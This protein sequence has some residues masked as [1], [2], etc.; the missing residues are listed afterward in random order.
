MVYNLERI[1]GNNYATKLL[2]LTLKRILS[3]PKL[4]NFLE[5]RGY[6]LRLCLHSFFNASMVSTLL[7]NSSSSKISW[8]HANQTD[9]M[10]ELAASSLLITDY[11]SVGFDFAF[12][13]KPVVLFM[14][15]LDEYGK[16]R[17]FY[18]NIDEL[19][20]SA[21][22]SP[23]ELINYLLE[24]KY[25]TNS[26]FRNRLPE[27]IDYEYVRSGKHIERM[28][29][30]FRNLQEHRITFIGYNFYGIGGTVLATRALAE[31][32][33]EQGYMV[34]LLSLK[35]NQ[36]PG[37]VP[38]A[39]NMKALYDEKAKTKRNRLK[40]FLF[41]SSKLYQWLRFD[42]DRCHLIPY[43]G[44][45]LKRWLDQAGS[46]TVISTRESLHPFLF[47]GSSKRIKNKVYYYHCVASVFETVFPRLSEQLKFIQPEKA[48]FVTENNRLNFIETYHF[49]P[50]QQYL[51]LGNTLDS[52]RM[53]ERD[54]IHPIVPKEQYRGVYLIRISSERKDDIDNLLNYG[55]YL[56]EHHYTDIRIDLY[57]TGD[58]LDEF[59]QTLVEE[60]LTKYICYCGFTKNPRGV[61]R[62][63]DAVVDFST[64]HSFGMPYIEGI[65]NGKMVFCMR[66]PGS[67][68]VMREIP[69]AFIESFDDL[70][71]KIRQLPFRPIEELTH[72]YDVISARY[73]RKAV[74]DAFIQYALKVD[75]T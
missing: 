17:S 24:E 28:Y 21:I 62:S 38:Y 19:E 9:V 42:K 20:E 67:E 73:S 66:N 33:L 1:F 18:C 12:L 3:D 75:D 68:E 50:Y 8:V 47:Y 30:Y 71:M 61:I 46:E 7:E 70:T 27:V 15:D 49:E 35:Q 72:Y 55:R 6:E 22:T 36:K 51:A 45:A 29:R 44:Y 69:E 57:G 39:L 43:S 48:I 40:K 32:L 60:E 2:I 14:P 63:H 16:K 34:Q 53:I 58:Y 74:S 23:T 13:G 54:Q 11:S 25:E 31:G 4:L 10:D 59:L 26:F 41:K 65:L 52:S 64:N 56:K 37:D 5:E